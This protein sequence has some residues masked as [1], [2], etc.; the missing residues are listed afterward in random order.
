[1]AESLVLFKQ[2]LWL[3][4]MLSA[5]ALLAATLIGVA[6]SLLQALT[7]IQDQTLPYVIKVVVVSVVLIGTG[8]WMGGEVLALTV[9]CMDLISSVGR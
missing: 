3:T 9:R 5:P 7:Q 6:I 1:M 4:V 8:R 2:A